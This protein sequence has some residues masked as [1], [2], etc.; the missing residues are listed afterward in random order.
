MK[1]LAIISKLQPLASKAKLFIE[2]KAPEIMIVAG[3]GG[4]V[5]AGVV[6][7]K[8]TAD[9]LPDILEEHDE[10]EELINNAECPEHTPEEDA[11]DREKSLKKLARHTSFLI[12]KAYALPVGM[13]V[14]ST[15]AILSGNHLLRKRYVAALAGLQALQ[16]SYDK[17]RSRI[18]DKFGEAADH[19]AAYGFE[20]EE[21][22]DTEIDPETGKEKKVKK[23]RDRVTD[24]SAHSPYF[25][26]ITPNDSLYRECHGDPIYMRNQL[27]IYQSICN[28]MY[29]EGH[30]LYYNNVMTF[31]FGN[32][33]EVMSDDGQIVGWYKYDKRNKQLTDDKLPVDFRIG[34]VH[35][36]N[37]ETD[38]DEIWFY[39]DPNVAGPVTLGH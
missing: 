38:Q 8:I 11:E 10:M 3:I 30:P 29:D 6:A 27:E 13:A 5:A 31:I 23:T 26:Y 20:E 14:V 24:A 12:C 25:R 16:S 35:N 36:H 37:D 17:Y 39:I 1:K 28:R 15:A 9:K 32:E 2:D 21:Y 19:Y 33:P 34:T 22:E 4:I 7:C 18:G